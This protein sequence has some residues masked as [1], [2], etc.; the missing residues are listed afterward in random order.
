MPVGF[1]ILSVVVIAFIIAVPLVFIFAFWLPNY[2]SVFKRARQIDPS[3][4]TFA[5]AQFVLQK[6]I[7]ESAGQ[8]R[9]AD[10]SDDDRGEKKS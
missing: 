2:R 6:H 10:K 3:V 4:K 8:N 5:D 7:M 9:N 1:I